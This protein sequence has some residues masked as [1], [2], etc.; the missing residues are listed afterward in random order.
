MNV[1]IFADESGHSGKEIFN[2]PNLYYQCAII[3]PE[4]SLNAFDE[5]LQKWCKNLNV[6]RLHAKDIPSEI[7][8]LIFDEIT[9]LF[10]KNKIFANTT[11]VE[12]SYIPALKIVDSFFDPWENQGS[13]KLW[14]ITAHFRHALCLVVDQLLDEDEK[15][16]FYFG[17]LKDDRS[18]YTEILETLNDR[19]ESNPSVDGRLRVVMCEAFDWAIK[20]M[21]KMTINHI[22]NRS[23]YKGNT[24]NLIAFSS[25]LH[26]VKDL[27][28]EKGWV[29]NSLIHDE[30]NEFGNTMKE[31]QRI[32]GSRFLKQD[33]DFFP[34]ISKDTVPVERFDVCSSKK[35]SLLQVVDI[36]LWHKVKG[37]AKAIPNQDDFY[38]TRAMSATIVDI[39]MNKLFQKKM[40]KS[41]IERGKKMMYKFEQ[42]YKDQK[43]IG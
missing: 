15:K 16:R 20:N 36:F 31:Y 40:S 39:G 34:K 42:Q 32:F 11:I 33:I 14:Y 37:L 5:F 3:V 1:H 30:Q 7:R 38:I 26:S 24:P 27:A 18:V 25:M 29:V 41:D 6:E 13:R 22:E 8:K 21:D 35:E 9:P 12:K 2:E 19:L 23:S 28:N 10:E 17:Y 43:N 4:N